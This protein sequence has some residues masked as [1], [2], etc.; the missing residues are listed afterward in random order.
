MSG[1]PTSPFEFAHAPYGPCVIHDICGDEPG[2]IIDLDQP[3][4]VDDVVSIAW[5]PDSRFRL[6]CVDGDEAWALDLAD[7]KHLTLSVDTL[8][9]VK[10]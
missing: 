5:M 9:R 2:C 8:E 6:V 3:F 10:P 7:G 1:T 4:A